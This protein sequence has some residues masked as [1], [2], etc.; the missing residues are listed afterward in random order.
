MSFKYYILNPDHSFTGMEFEDYLSHIKSLGI[1]GE[2]RRVDESQIGNYRI[3][4]VFLGIDHNWNDYGPPIL[5]ETMIF[6]PHFERDEYQ[7]RCATWNEAL[8]MHITAIDFVNVH[9]LKWWFQDR[10]YEI[11]KIF[12]RN[13]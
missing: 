7:T 13:S 9:R 5:F 11:K 4:T 2:N 10:L 1:N 12:W 6:G 3:S 8:E